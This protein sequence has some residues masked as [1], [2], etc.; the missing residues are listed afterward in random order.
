MS[1]AESNE[2]EL[3]HSWIQLRRWL[4]GDGNDQ[5]GK[6]LL[7]LYWHLPAHLGSNSSTELSLV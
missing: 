3:F 2:V 5:A 6:T 4:F 1:K 7:L